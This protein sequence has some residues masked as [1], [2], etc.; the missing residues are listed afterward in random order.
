MHLMIIVK[1]A[2]LIVKYAFCSRC[3]SALTLKE[4]YPGLCNI[5]SFYF[6]WSAMGQW[7]IALHNVGMCLKQE[8]HCTILQCANV[9]QH[10]TLKDGRWL[11]NSSIV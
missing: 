1:Q 7:D 8:A 6:A 10:D 5:C 2:S 11:H 4:R 9:A 3:A